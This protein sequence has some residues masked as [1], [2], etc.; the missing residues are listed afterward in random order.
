MRSDYDLQ[1]VVVA[2]YMIVDRVYNNGCMITG[3]S[4]HNWRVERI[5]RDVFAS[6]F[7][8]TFHDLEDSNLLDP[9]TE[10]QILSLHR[11]FIP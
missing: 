3:S 2:K 8:Q 1:N 9:L 10:K 11:K 6:N 7:C 5:Q 4:V